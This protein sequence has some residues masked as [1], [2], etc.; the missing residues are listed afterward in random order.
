MSIAWSTEDCTTPGQAPRLQ[1][2]SHNALF[3]CAFIVVGAC[4]GANLFVGVLVNFWNEVS[5]TSLLTS[6]QEEWMLALQV[7]KLTQPR[8]KKMTDYGIEEGSCRARLYGF[9]GTSTWF[10]VLSGA[11]V[12][13]NTMLLASESWPQSDAF[14]E[15][16]QALNL[17]FL[18]FFSIELIVKLWCFGFD[19][20]WSDHFQK[21]DWAVV[22][23][24]WMAEAFNG[25]GM[26]SLR[27]LRI[28]RALKAFNW[29]ET[30]R[31]LALTLIQSIVP[32]FYLFSLILLTIFVYAI[33]GMQLFGQLPHGDRINS[34]DNFDDF[35]SAGRVLYQVGVGA[36]FATMIMELD[37]RGTWG[38]FALFSSF[39]VIV[40]WVVVNLLIAA[41]LAAFEANFVADHM[42][43]RPA[44]ID[45]FTAVWCRQVEAVTAET[46]Q[47]AA[48]SLGKKARGAVASYPMSKGM[49]A[50]DE[51]SQDRLAVARLESLMIELKTKEECSELTAVMDRDP[52]YLNRIR[53]ELQARRRR[54]ARR[55]PHVMRMSSAGSPR[56]P[57]QT[58]VEDPQAS[59]ERAGAEWVN[60]ES[61]P[62]ETVSLSELLLTLALISYSYECL[63]LKERAEAAREWEASRER[64][65]SEL[66]HI[67][68]RHALL[69]R[70]LKAEP[71]GGDG[72]ESRQLRAASKVIVLVRMNALVRL[73]KVNN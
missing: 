73:K 71:D 13:A 19:D 46:K 25:V 44:V 4:F 39:Y 29:S 33:A 42:T 16:S 47:E 15:Q 30:L 57:H 55:D 27:S 23:G 67:M 52:H 26:Q 51:P 60:L 50:T 70:R 10:D 11:M 17:G 62:K 37:R 45:E 5:G 38:A 20:L 63:D 24:S 7:A 31:E 48:K 2:E 40:Q 53:F 36:D 22:I 72:V 18:L 65:A 35:F 14:T 43:L 6:A 34:Q 28:L 8:E 68:M 58:D 32:A 64:F 61:K 49:L 69:V 56:S 3:I 9:I 66:I 1:N 41:L 12:A 54:V 21:F 59:A